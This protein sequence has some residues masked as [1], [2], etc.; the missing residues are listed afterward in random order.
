MGPLEQLPRLCYLGTNMNR[1]LLILACLVCGCAT[2]A[3]PSR[4]VETPKDEGRNA[5]IGRYVNC[6]LDYANQYIASSASA[7]EIA[8]AAVAT[9]ETQLQDLQRLMTAAMVERYNTH[10][11]RQTAASGVKELTR[12]FRSKARGQV[13][14]KVLELRDRK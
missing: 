10:A 12:D 9:C 4:E 5:L 3:E 1:C 11:G 13:I 14:S 6:T 7:S 2:V 8:D